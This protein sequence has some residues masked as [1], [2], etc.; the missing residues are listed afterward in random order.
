[1]NAPAVAVPLVSAPH[2]HAPISVGYIMRQVILALIPATLFGV[3]IFGF[4]VLYLLIVSLLTA[5]ASEAL[6]LWIMKKPIVPFLNDGSAV[7]TGWLVAMSLPPWAPWWIAVVGVCFAVIIGKQMYGG[8]GQNVF[9]PA[10][11]AR[12]MLLIAF[13]VEMTTWIHPTPL[14]TAHAPGIIDS[15]GITFGGVIPNPD[16]FTGASAL[17]Y[18]KTQMSMGHTAGEAL[19]HYSALES[20]F[21]WRL[22]SMGETSA[23]LLLLG[24]IYLIYKKIITWHV[25]VAMLLTSFVVATI[26]SFINPDR[27]AGG[28]FHIF[29]GGAMLIAFFIATDPVTAPSS[30][31]GLIIFGIGIG[32]I[33]YVIRTWGAFPEGV[34]FAVLLM[35]ALAPLIDHYVRPRIYGRTY[36]GKPIDV[37][38]RS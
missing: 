19:Q 35:N 34:G 12:V 5:L 38:P 10:M 20:F 3:C 4:P 31:I 28:I 16:G 7:L 27:F 8:L 21:G 24:G 36:S 32:L 26:F 33:E 25:P 29:N 23:L 22:G 37:K 15:F 18:L 1:M 2:A 14:F 30:K 13:P 6:M 9:N 11:L 17:G